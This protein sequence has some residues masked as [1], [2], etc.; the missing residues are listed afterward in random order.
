MS[1]GWRSAPHRPV[2]DS[3]R[4][5]VA[6]LSLRVH[7]LHRHDHRVGRLVPADLRMETGTTRGE[8]NTFSFK[9]N[10]F[11]FKVSRLYSGSSALSFTVFFPSLNES[12]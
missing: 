6:A 3:V 2:D 7:Q 4:V 12:F 8:I 11:K 5:E 1:D 9:I 10:H